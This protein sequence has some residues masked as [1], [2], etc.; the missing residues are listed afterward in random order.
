MD[1]RRTV[2][3]VEEVACGPGRPK[4]A[5]SKDHLQ[6]LIEMDL[7]VP[8]ISKMLGI[9][10]RTIHRRMQEWGLSV[11]NTYSKLTDHELDNLVR[12][13]KATS[14]DLGRYFV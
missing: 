4:L 7:N 10:E 14:P 8:C 1:R 3:V 13:I 12:T 2:I 11:R 5:V 6:E 9:S